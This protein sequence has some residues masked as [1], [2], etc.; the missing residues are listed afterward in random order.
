MNGNIQK[1]LQAPGGPN[2]FDWTYI[3]NPPQ[4]MY[5][6]GLG[7]IQIL[8]NGNRLINEGR[9]GRAFEIT[10]AGE[11]V[12]EYVNPMKNGQPIA[13]YDTTLTPSINQQ[14]RFLRYPPNFAAFNGRTLDPIGYIELNPDTVYCATILNVEQ[15]VPYNDEVNVFPNP[16]STDVVVEFEN[17]IERAR[18]IEVYDLL[19]RLHLQFETFDQSNLLNLQN[20]ES[21]L[22]LLRVDGKLRNKISVLK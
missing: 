11:T 20:L 21:G 7:A 1:I 12:W 14:F 5:S 9:R 18:K 15:I 16:T 6:T 8:P 10:N 13:Q 17:I 19:G 4:S 2:T 22:Y 3:A